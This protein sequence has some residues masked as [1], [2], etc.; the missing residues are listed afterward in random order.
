MRNLELAVRH[1]GATRDNIVRRSI[2]TTQPYEL[3]TLTGAVSDTTKGTATMGAAKP[4]R[5]SSV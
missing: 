4:P 2:Y 1:V 5:Q 3:A